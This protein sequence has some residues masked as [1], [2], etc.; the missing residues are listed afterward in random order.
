M[1]TQQPMKRR[2]KTGEEETEPRPSTL[3]QKTVDKLLDLLTTLE[4]DLDHVLPVP[5][6]PNDLDNQLNE[7]R[8]KEFTA[9]KVG[10]ESMRIKLV[11]S[12][13]QEKEQREI[14]SSGVDEL[15]GYLSRIKYLAVEVHILLQ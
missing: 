9:I 2:T 12:R 5:E 11:E 4:G 10:I 14:L 15:E 6:F 13:H 8:V 7:F 1:L 3:Q